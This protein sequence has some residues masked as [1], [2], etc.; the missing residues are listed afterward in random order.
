M[1]NYIMAA[2]FV[3]IALA[4]LYA[5]LFKGATHQLFMAAIGFGVAIALYIDAKNLSHGK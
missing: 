4:A 2:L 5:A 3:L 1:H